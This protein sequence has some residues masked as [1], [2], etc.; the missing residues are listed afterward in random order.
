MTATYDLGHSPGP[1]RVPRFKGTVIGKRRRVRE[2]FG[3]SM[4]KKRVHILSVVPLTH[5]R[6][7]PCCTC[8]PKTGVFNYANEGGVNGAPKGNGT[9]LCARVV[10]RAAASLP[11]VG[12]GV[13]AA[14]VFGSRAFLAPLRPLFKVPVHP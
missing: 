3:V 7:R 9:V 10:R 2:G 13:V 5:A 14:Y 12:V 11:G 1:V 8:T 4:Q 6:A